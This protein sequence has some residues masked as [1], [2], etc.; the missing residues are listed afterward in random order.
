MLSFSHYC[1]HSPF[2]PTLVSAVICGSHPVAA[3]Y[4]L[5]ALQVKDPG[6][7]VQGNWQQEV[8]AASIIANTWFVARKDLDS[9]LFLIKWTT[10]YH[11][12]F[13]S[14]AINL[15]QNVPNITLH[16][17]QPKCIFKCMWQL[18]WTVESTGLFE[19]LVFI[20]VLSKRPMALFPS[21]PFWLS[22]LCRAGFCCWGSITVTQHTDGERSR[23][24]DSVC[25]KGSPL[26]LLGNTCCCLNLALF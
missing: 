22:P 13:S 6:H 3:G 21:C 23:W 14:I 16:S 25:I 12:I 19:V 7:S 8:Y 20:T 15:L 4:N 10:G 5:L 11:C 18:T 26:R 1:A 24:A 9:F 17:A 2:R